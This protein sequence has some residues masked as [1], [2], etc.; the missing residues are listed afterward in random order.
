MPHIY[1]FMGYK[2]ARV[3]IEWLC[4]AFGL[5]SMPSTTARTAGSTSGRRAKCCSGAVDAGCKADAST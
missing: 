4:G 3:A 2:D 1:P 5:R